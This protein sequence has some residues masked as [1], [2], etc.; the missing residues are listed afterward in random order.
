MT[1][2]VSI[3]MLTHNAPSFVETSIRTVFERTQG[4]RYELVVV[5][6]ASGEQTRQLVKK[7]RAEGLID[8]LRLLE[9]NS[10]FAEG[11]NRAADMASADATHFLLLNSDVEVRGVDW[12]DHL[13]K[14]HERGITAYGWVDGQFAR[15]DG[16]CL[17]I[18][19]DLYRIHQLDEDHQWWWAITKLQAKLLNEGFSVKGYKDH[20]RYL[21]HFGGASGDGFKAARGMEVTEDQVEGWFAGKRPRKINGHIHAPGP[22]ESPRRASN[23]LR[24]LMGRGFSAA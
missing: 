15:V 9:H 16:Y 20:E 14:I 7:L 8:R 17:L 6:N 12:L 3:L 5:D 13:L 10:F 18:D 21:H 22:G 1:A 4:V 11:N 2:S 24:R 19:A 23:W